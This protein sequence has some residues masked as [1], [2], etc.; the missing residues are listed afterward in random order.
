VLHLNACIDR[1]SSAYHVPVA[2]IESAIHAPHAP[3]EIGPMGIPP[4]WL[5]VLA[6]FGF[7]PTKILADNCDNVA[8]GTWILAAMRQHAATSDTPPAPTPDA[9]ALPACAVEAAEAYHASQAEVARILSSPHSANSVGPMGVP[10][11]WLPILQAYGFNTY[12]VEHDACTGIAAGAWILG[13]EAMENGGSTKFSTN[14]T[15]SPTP[16]AWLLPI[17]AQASVKYDLPESLLLAIAAQE[18]H[19]D[20]FALSPAGAQ[21]LMQLMPGTAAQ[22]SVTAP[23]NAAQSIM[24]GA[25]YL[26]DLRAQFSGNVPLM[27]A[28]YNAGSANVTAYGGRIPPFHE[29]EEYVPSVIAR[30]RIYSAQLHATRAADMMP[31]GA[32]APAQPTMPHVAAAESAMARARTK[33][34]RA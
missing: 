3:N 27:L 13:V 26:A 32:G 19:F 20:P 21:G 6:R 11:A 8:A 7:D 33:H 24:G 9:P 18:S 34:A 25:A 2:R 16:P 4:A 31:P 22:Y 1:I 17:F 29:T 15:S 23:Y 30:Y 14:I 5:P 12:L 28:A 10:L